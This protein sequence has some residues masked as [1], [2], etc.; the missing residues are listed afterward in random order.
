M[1]SMRI[2]I[3]GATGFV[4][5]NLMPMLVN[6]CPEAE[7]LVLC[8]NVDRAHALFPN[9]SV[10]FKEAED[11]DSV[12]AFNPQIILHLAS[13]S[14]SRNDTDIIQPLLQS[15]ILYGIQLLDALKECKSLKLFVNTGSF[16]E[17]R[18]GTEAINDA[19]LYTATKSAF[20]VFVDY[21]SQ[22][23]QFKYI[24]V[25]P[26]TIYGGKPT[27]KRLMDYI[28]ESMDSKES[29]DMTAGEQILDFTHVDDLCDFYVHVVE[30]VE[31]I[32]DIKNGESFHIGTGR[33]TTIRELA[34]MMEHVYGKKCYIHWGG[35][36][37]RDRDTMQAAAPIAKNIS[38]L[39]WKAKISLK[40]GILKMKNQINYE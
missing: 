30:N 21:Y 9:L 22:L 7:I 12:K 14:T 38:L 18:F 19:Y 11:W 13:L 2:L 27:V 37:Y 8:R 28:L 35:R 26:Y 33:G 25:I 32:S 10:L 34:S 15:N 5:Q 24:N 31:R 29:V 40:D 16:A 4:G 1:C 20:R 36:P 3:T 17:Y 39:E 23:C 6:K